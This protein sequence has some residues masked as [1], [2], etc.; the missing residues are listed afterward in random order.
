MKKLLIPFVFLGLHIA[1]FAQKQGQEKVDS[2]MEILPH[3]K[4]DTIK[5]R[6]F[7]TIAEELFFIDTQQALEYG[8]KGLTHVTDMKWKRGIAVFNSIL[9]RAYSDLGNY[10]SSKTY[11]QKALAIHSESKDH[12]NIAS[13]LNNLGS[14]ELNLRSDFPSAIKY[15]YKALHQAELVHDTYLITICYDNISTVYFLQ[16]NYPQAIKFSFKSLN[17]L[18]RETKAGTFNL[19]REI[20]NNLSNI[21]SIYTE[22]KEY[23]KA[24][25]YLL[26]AIKI[27]K[28]V[29]NKQGLAKCYSNLSI[30][31]E[32]DYEKKIHFLLEAKQLYD[33]LNTNYIGS[34][35]NIANLGI[36]YFDW[37]RTDTLASTKLTELQRAEMLR[38][39]ENYLKQAIKLS[40]NNGELAYH[41]SF[42]GNLSEIQ[43]FKGDYLNAYQ[44]FRTYHQIEDSLYSQKSKNE[45]A[46][47]ASEREIALRDKEIEINKL[48]LEV[49]KKQ[50]IGML[51]GIG[52]L[53]IIGGLLFWQ[54]QTRK[55]TN[56]TL[57]HLNNELDEANKIKAKFF[58]I[59]S[60]DL[61]SPVANLISFLHLQKA[62]PDLLSAESSE[63][64]QKRITESAE[65]LLDTMESMLLWSKGQMQNF[66]PQVKQLEV[67]ELFQ[68]LQKFFAS[69]SDIE[70]TFD[71]PENLRLVSDE[72]YLKTI[73]QNLTNN[74][75][76]ALK[77]R[78]NSS[79][80]WEA[81]TESGQVVLAIIDN[82]PGI[83]EHQLGTLFTEDSV[84]SS[85]VGLGLHLIRDLAKSIACKIAV[86][87]NPGLGS[88]FQLIFGKG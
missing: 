72:D 73:M 12:F 9:G 2:L 76:K 50:Q 4:N 85:K 41:N 53:A 1:A 17:L 78:P 62:D 16:K 64:H 28:E 46:T 35:N 71:N 6:L 15:F 22:M 70:F 19:T 38:K 30:L 69:A 36:A 83:S 54:N 44:N 25:E 43:A 57:L 86:K 77:N 23:T 82:G 81:R 40:H 26:K 5:G 24:N 39:A 14:L 31:Y 63:M 61:R 84:I 52:F 65:T 88:E 3:I 75:V 49:K 48:A 21:G 20:G 7:K 60:H 18:Q 32:S 42:L 37:V 47:I 66:K 67:S 11:N 27:H 45:I 55:R 34:I 68:Y 56:V 33:E 13:V 51:T 79:I 80:R 29:Q 58:A 87:S 59:L 10:D 8:H 74:A